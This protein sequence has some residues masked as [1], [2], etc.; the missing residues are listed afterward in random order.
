M[1]KVRTQGL[2]KLMYVMASIHGLYND[3]LN[4]VESVEMPNAVE[5]VVTGI[6]LTSWVFKP[7]H[8]QPAPSGGD[9]VPAV[10]A[11]AAGRRA[12]AA[13]GPC[14]YIHMWYSCYDYYY[15]YY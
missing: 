12:R 15:Y 7:V 9:V 10:R 5:S 13:R 4:A 8:S 6:V 3:T 2:L 11:E 1:M 14:M